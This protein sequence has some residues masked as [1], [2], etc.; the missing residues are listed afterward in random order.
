MTYVFYP[1]FPSC[2]IGV[3]AAMAE[4]TLLESRGLDIQFPCGLKSLRSRSTSKE[5]AW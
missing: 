3:P 1:G 2:Y 5:V 4:H